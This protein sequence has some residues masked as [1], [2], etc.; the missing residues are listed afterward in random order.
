[1]V[2]SIALFAIGITSIRLIPLELDPEVELPK[3]TISCSW[4]NTSAVSIEAE[5]TAPI[6]SAIQSLKGIEKIISDTREGSC[7]IVV[8][9]D[10]KTN[11]RLAELDLNEKMHSL[12]KEFPEE[13]SFPEISRS[14]PESL[15][16]LKGFMRLELVGPWEVDRIR[17][18]A[19]DH[20]RLPLSSV[21]FV[22]KVSIRGGSERV[23][24]IVVD[25]ASLQALKIP[26]VEVE[27]ALHFLAVDGRRL[28]TF[29]ERGYSRNVEL[30]AGIERLG[31]IADIP[32]RKLDSGRIIT[33]DDI[34]DIKFQ[35]NQSDNIV[36]RNR[37]NIVEI[38][39]D[40]DA[41]SSILEVARAVD[42]K[43]NF[44]RQ[45]LPPELNLVKSEDKSQDL[46]DEL[47]KL[48]HRSC[49]SGVL[50]GIFILFF[51]RKFYITFILFCPIL[52]AY[53]GSVSAL[54]VLGKSLNVLTLT[55][56][57]MAGGILI[58][59]A[60]VV[61]DS[62]KRKGEQVICPQDDTLLHAITQGTEK[63][64]LPLLC[65]NLTTL[66]AFVPVFFIESELKSVLK[67]FWNALSLTLLF[68]LLLSIFLIPLLARFNTDTLKTK[69][70]ASHFLLA[71]FYRYYLSFVLNH[72]ILILFIAIWLFGIPIWLLPNY[73][74]PEDLQDKGEGH[75]KKE[76]PTALAG[77]NEELPRWAQLY[78]EWWNE[79]ALKK[80]KPILFKTLGGSTYL[81]FREVPKGEIRE[82]SKNTYIRIGVEMP[83][84]VEIEQIEGIC[85]LFEEYVVLYGDNIEDLLTNIKKDE[86]VVEIHI[87]DEF[88]GTDFP[89]SLYE[90]VLRLSK[91]ID[92]IS[93][94]VS[95]FGEGFANQMSPT[96]YHHSLV[97]SGYEFKKVHEIA[98]DIAV[99][100]KKNRRINDVDIDLNSRW[101][102]KQYEVVGDLDRQQMAIS[103]ISHREILNQ[104]STLIGS[105]KD[106]TV[107]LGNK[108][109]RTSLVL[110]GTY[111]ATL[112]EIKRSI[113]NK[114]MEE[115]RREVRV[116]DVVSIHT[117]PILPAIRRENQSYTRAINFNFVGQQVYGEKFARM[118]A[119]RTELP[120]GY[121]L[122][123]PKDNRRTDA[124]N[125]ELLIAVLFSILI[126]WMISAAVLESWFQ[127]LIILTAIPLS[128]IGFF[129]S[130]YFFESPFDSGGYVA[131]FML[132]GIVV[133]NSILLVCH[134]ASETKNSGPIYR[135]VL[136]E[137]ASEKLYP[138]LFTTSTT[139]LGMLPLVLFENS[140]SIWYP[141]AVGV[142]GGIIVSTVMVLTIIP[143]LF[144][145]FRMYVRG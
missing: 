74:S 54:Y 73:I 85:R 101:A 102:K 51:Y 92:G 120:F 44:L 144:S 37:H 61:F 138:I 59:N 38:E 121:S 113:L 72:K 60:I 140:E 127:P 10:E 22:D 29:D 36:R 108:F 33:L 45:S 89:S 40:K 82:K 104:V 126:V 77:A 143:I 80:K 13:V 79:P 42:K 69:G 28:G 142:I 41:G 103:D 15:K 98:K 30:S 27:N 63:T 100:L 17:E 76:T 70:R 97:L 81:F 99:E 75:G 3:L 52:L 2:S 133:N 16:L 115:T 57:T 71:R 107:R 125:R 12:F 47:N 35:R 128:L 34:A 46:Q 1:M 86:G 8:S 122:I 117:D 58:D 56:F 109:Y 145:F 87:K 131:L 88:V 124:Q 139:V 134:I 18:Y 141:M 91:Y 64:V 106:G 95:G 111:P 96:W 55:G 123:N 65:A 110:S 31:D 7:I 135:S 21:Q 49:Y 137:L 48:W 19:E 11:L 136:I 24:K 66:G 68:S 62:I 84:N 132:T 93:I 105:G 119:D 6:E 53:T 116:S 50:I 112:Q 14:V 23:Y 43:I 25:R 26:L 67:P 32:I 114:G 39:I 83:H 4:P 130:Y 90:E 118:K 129:F 20:L 9:F 94:N 5:V 78:N